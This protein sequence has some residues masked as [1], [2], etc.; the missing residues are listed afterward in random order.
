MSLSGH[1]RQLSHSTT[2]DE[3]QH[4][5][6]L[7]I[8]IG[9]ILVLFSVALAIGQWLHHRHIYWLP[10]SAATIL[11]GLVFGLIFTVM[12]YEK[13]FPFFE[14]DVTPGLKDLLTFDPEFFTLF[15]LPPIIFEAGFNM[16]AKAFFANITPTIFFAFGGTFLSTFVVG[17]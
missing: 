7:A 15:L 8:T 14:Q 2:D 3:V 5:E 4:D 12:D 16:D 10:E 1:S 6:T 17:G 9:V 13:H 11:V